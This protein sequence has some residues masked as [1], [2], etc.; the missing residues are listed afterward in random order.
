[1]KAQSDDSQDTK[2]DF[3]SILM[4]GVVEGYS[5]LALAMK[6][7]EEKVKDEKGL[8]TSKVCNTK[9]V[10]AKKVIYECQNVKS[11]LGCGLRRFSFRLLLDVKSHREEVNEEVHIFKMIG[12]TKKMFTVKE[13]KKY[14]DDDSQ[15]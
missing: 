8:E 5:S 7:F 12:V 11:F 1:V 10:G 13:W 6:K 4:P 9:Q 15:P 2:G 14:N 3:E